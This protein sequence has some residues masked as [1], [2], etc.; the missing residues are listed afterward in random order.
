MTHSS[1]K[2]PH[3]F[4]DTLRLIQGDPELAVRHDYPDPAD[5]RFA[6]V[7]RLRF[8]RELYEEITAGA[9]TATDKVLAVEG[10]CRRYF[11]HGHKARK[12][13]E[14]VWVLDP[15][16]NYHARFLQCSEVNRLLLDILSAG[17]I[18]GRIVILSMHQA[19]EARVEGRWIYLDADLFGFAQRALNDRG[20]PASV[21]DIYLDP[22][23]ADRL[24][25]NSENQFA[26]QAVGESFGATWYPGYVFRELEEPLPG[27]PAIPSVRTRSGTP[28]EWAALPDFG[29][30]RQEG[31][32]HEAL[33]G[34]ARPVWPRRRRSLTPRWTSIEISDGALRLGWALPSG[35]REEGLTFRVDIASE[36]RDWC[37]ADWR[38][39][40]AL[41]PWWTFSGRTPAN[42][43]GRI[44]FLPND[45]LGCYRT[46]DVSIAIG[47]RELPPG[48][49]H[50]ALSAEDAH[51]RETGNR[52]YMPSEEICVDARRAEDSTAC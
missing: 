51:G 20:E 21:E 19:A 44:D 26:R 45:D 50:I 32:E 7:D 33:A 39:D 29:W 13:A 36:S 18:E 1:L 40:E 2:Q 6:S 23:I 42:D 24:V 17:G 4:Y 16:V 49:V 5:E 14:G 11:M 9:A 47:L 46:D 15:I 8:L 38:C 25:G 22:R 12:T 52:R 43:Y 37:Y 34:G 48:P 41:R 31:G 35:P 3:D 28:E 27:R 30:R 10:F